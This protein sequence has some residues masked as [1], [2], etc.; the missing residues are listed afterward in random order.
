MAALAGMAPARNE[1]SSVD[2]SRGR[3]NTENRFKH[4]CVAPLYFV[5]HP[6]R[7]LV[8]SS[9]L[10]FARGDDDCRRTNLSNAYRQSA[11]AP[12]RTDATPC[13]FLLPPVGLVAVQNAN[14]AGAYFGATIIDAGSIENADFTDAQF[15]PKTLAL[16][17]DR[18]DMKGT[19]PATG[20][21]TRDSAMCP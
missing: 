11:L 12:A 16:M 3:N 14:V 7:F 4:A 5:S 20:A 2:S 19:N 18:P 8:L 1:I 6:K 10:N 13:S 17:C 15:P 21:D 9:P